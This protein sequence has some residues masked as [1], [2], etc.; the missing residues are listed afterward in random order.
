M[1]GWFLL[2]CSIAAATILISGHAIIAN[3]GGNPDLLTETV[4]TVEQEDGYCYELD[5]HAIELHEELLEEFEE[6]EDKIDEIYEELDNQMDWLYHFMYKF[7]DDTVANHWFAPTFAK[8]LDVFFSR[9]FEGY[10]D[11]F[12]VYLRGVSE[13]IDLVR[14]LIEENEEAIRGEYVYFDCDI[15]EDIVI[16][17]SQEGMSIIKNVLENDTLEAILN[18]T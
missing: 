13:E 7:E 18:V 17:N 16:N 6:F 11:T 3:A 2:G 15:V 14:T 4:S 1:I 10:L 8:N 12:E 9:W 5:E